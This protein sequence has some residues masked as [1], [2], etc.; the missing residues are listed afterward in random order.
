V[1]GQQDVRVD[2][3]QH[4]PTRRG[5]ELGAG[6][7]LAREAG[8]GIRAAQHAQPGIA[9]CDGAHDLRGT[10]G[11]AVVEDQQLQVRHLALVQRGSHGGRDPVRLVADR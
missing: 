4:A 8:N 3:D 6:V 9:V 2:E 7:R 1:R 10:V 11:R 5:G